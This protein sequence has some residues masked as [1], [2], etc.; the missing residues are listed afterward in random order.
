MFTSITES[1]MSKVPSKETSTCY[2]VPWINR[3]C[4]RLSRCQKQA[5]KKAKRTNTDSDWER[6][7]SMRKKNKEAC[8]SAYTTHVNET[9][10]SENPKRFY[11]YIKSKKQDRVGVSTL[12]VNDT[13]IIDD[14]KKAEILNHQYYSVFSVPDGKKPVIPSCIDHS[15]NDFTISAN[16]IL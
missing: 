13:L 10:M 5:Y 9:I 4:K 15:I 14:E 8:Q 12:K 7:R 1:A 3:K 6:F 11:S 2:N 16:G